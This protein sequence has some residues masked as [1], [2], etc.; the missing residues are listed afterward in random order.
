MKK[1]EHLGIAVTDLQASINMFEK[2]L[3]VSC[4][5]LE[6]V[7]SEGVRTAFFSSWRI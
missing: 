4:Y 7:A 5:K 2:L 6:E 3:N 1:I